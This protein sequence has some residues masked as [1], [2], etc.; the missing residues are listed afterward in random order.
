M[1]HEKEVL[2]AAVLIVVGVVGLLK[3]W[4]DK[5]DSKNLA[6]AKDALSTRDNQYLAVSLVALVCG[7]ALLY[8]E[9]VHQA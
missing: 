4:K 2:I 6:C 5:K 3:G 8:L 1:A 9:K 7:A